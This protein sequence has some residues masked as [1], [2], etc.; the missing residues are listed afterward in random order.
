MQ[1]ISCD[2][3]GGN[4]KAYSIWGGEEIPYCF[5]SLRGPGRQLDYSLYDNPIH[6]SGESGQDWF[7][8]DLALYESG[9][10]SNPN[11]SKANND[12]VKT[13]IM[14]CISKVARTSNLRIMVGIR[15]RLFNPEEYKALKEEYENKHIQIEDHITG[16]ISTYF[17]DEI[18]I[19]L[20]SRG[21]YTYES[22]KDSSL[23]SKPE[24][25]CLTFGYKTVEVGFYR[26][27]VY[28]KQNSFSVELGAYQALKEVEKEL[29]KKGLVYNIEQIDDSKEYN[30]L[31]SYSYGNLYRQIINAI[32]A[33][34]PNFSHLPCIVSGGSIETFTAFGNRIPYIVSDDP[35]MAVAKGLYIRAKEVMN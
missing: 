2:I 15:D 26:R 4:V 18:C 9:Y 16:K 23:R 13:M 34:L 22:S 3:G 8:G 33:R 20:E 6:I 29:G 7:V 35:I 31:K 1:Y 11:D 28:N 30:H 27:G 25:I 17:I 19:D 21:L 14:A 24:L 5:K 32:Q 12:F 10:H